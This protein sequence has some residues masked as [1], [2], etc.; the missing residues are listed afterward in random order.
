MQVRH[1]WHYFCTSCRIHDEDH[2]PLSSVCS[3]GPVALLRNCSWMHGT[4]RTVF[5]DRF[6]TS[7][8][9]FLNLK[10]MGINAVGTIMGNRKGFSNLV[11]FNTHEVKT[12]G[13]GSLKM[14]K[15][16]IEGTSEHIL[17]IGWLD[18]KPIYMVA[19]GIASTG[20][21][22]IRRLKKG[23]TKVLIAY[24]PLQLYHQYMGG[25]DTNDYMRMGSYSLQRTYKMRYWPKTMFLALMD[26]VLVNIYIIYLFSYHYMCVF[27]SISRLT[28]RKYRRKRD[29]P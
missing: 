7:V 22:V 29:N 27:T 10:D 18:T 5:C 23:M 12:L 26:L 21:H 20:C 16:E 17:S 3:H 1:H 28:T 15:H 2:C 9:L 6:Y 11:K 14:M 19:T 13:R 8:G 4:H 24:R 25:V